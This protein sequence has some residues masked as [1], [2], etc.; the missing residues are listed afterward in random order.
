MKWIETGLKNLRPHWTMHA[1]Y[2]R[3]EPV[4]T[5]L[6]KWITSVR[7]ES[8]LSK[9]AIRADA[10]NPHS[11]LFPTRLKYG[12]ADTPLHFWLHSKH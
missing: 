4:S 6:Q 12:S 3:P 8:G 1:S 5:H 11:K 9:T 2:E 7:I 10:T